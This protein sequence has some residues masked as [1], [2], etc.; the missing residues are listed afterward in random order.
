M[1]TGGGGGLD[2]DGEVDDGVWSGVV[3]SMGSLRC[4]LDAGCFLL[5]CS[6]VRC[7]SWLGWLVGEWSDGCIVRYVSKVEWVYTH[8]LSI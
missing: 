4:I 6:F 2:V 8:S 3:A 7:E 1:E 5:V